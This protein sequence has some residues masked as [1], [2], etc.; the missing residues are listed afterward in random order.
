MTVLHTL[1]TCPF[2]GSSAKRYEF[3]THALG[4][5]DLSKKGQVRYMS[6]CS[7]DKG[8][9]CAAS[10]TTSFESQEQ[11]DSAWSTRA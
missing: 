6:Y 5:T 8:V 7:G 9:K 1:P 10:N 2:C 11:A 4:T 3:F